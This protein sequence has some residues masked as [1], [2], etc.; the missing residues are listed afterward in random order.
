MNVR[1]W[2]NGCKE[3]DQISGS[4]KLHIGDL[5]G[6]PEMHK[7]PRMNVLTVAMHKC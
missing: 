3:L 1:N 7:C 2:T 4:I 6:K 5:W